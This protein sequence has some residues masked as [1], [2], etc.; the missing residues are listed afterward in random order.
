MSRIRIST[1]V[2]EELLRAARHT[3][4]GVNDASLMDEALAALLARERAAVIEASY[5]SYDTHPIK[6]PDDWGDLDSFRRA[7][8]AS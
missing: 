1:T 4:A 5:E 7:A 6:E 8:A 2:D 3:R